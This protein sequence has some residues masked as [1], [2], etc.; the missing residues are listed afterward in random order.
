MSVILAR[1]DQRLIHGIT[2][3]QWNGLLKPKRFMVV[4]DVISEDDM[5]KASMRMSKPAGN[6]IK[7]IFVK[8]TSLYHYTL[9]HFI[10]FSGTFFKHHNHKLIF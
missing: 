4:D 6:V 2:V 8:F 1:V 5:V 10:P 3:N 9:K 7:L